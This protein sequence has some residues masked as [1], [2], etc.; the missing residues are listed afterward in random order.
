MLDFDYVMCSFYVSDFIVEVKVPSLLAA[1][2][3]KCL[4]GHTER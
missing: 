4:A 3:V 2:H 1:V